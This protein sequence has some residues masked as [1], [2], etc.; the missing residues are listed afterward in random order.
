MTLSARK[1]HASPVD[2][3]IPFWY[4]C[5]CCHDTGLIASHFLKDF[6]PDYNRNDSVP[7]VCM[8]RNCEKGRKQTTAYW[9]E[10]PDRE[11]KAKETGGQPTPSDLYRNWF[12]IRLLEQSCDKIHQ[13]EYQQWLKWK[14]N[15]I[16][17]KRKAIAAINQ[18]T[19]DLDN[20][21]TADEL[22]F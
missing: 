3:E 9:L 21:P 2:K 12:D 18:L 20:I 15:Q 10:D 8:R 6:V 4:R 7:F 14:D 5:G 11:K 22:D 19:A 13:L 17:G 1:I 16:E